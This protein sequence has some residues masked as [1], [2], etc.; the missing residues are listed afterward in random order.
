[1]KIYV[2]SGGILSID[3]TPAEIFQLE[4]KCLLFYLFWELWKNVSW[5]LTGECEEV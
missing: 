1:M 3:L 4:D 2:R 5:E